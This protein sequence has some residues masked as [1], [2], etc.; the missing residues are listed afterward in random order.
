MRPNLTG[1]ARLMRKFTGCAV[2]AC[3]GAS[4]AIGCG[5][6]RTGAGSHATLATPSEAPDGV[7]SSGPGPRWAD[8]GDIA[9]VLPEDLPPGWMVKLA[10]ERAGRPRDEWQDHFE[11][12]AGRD[13]FLILGAHRL[14]S[15]SDFGFGPP[16]THAVERSDAGRFMMAL[17]FV[18]PA[19][20]SAGLTTAPSA[21]DLRAREMRWR[22]DGF[23]FIVA[24]LSASPDDALIERIGDEFGRLRS[25][26]FPIPRSAEAAG[27]TR[28]GSAAGDLDTPDYTVSW[29]PAKFAGENREAA[30]AA[31]DEGPGLW[32]NVGSRFY[33][34]TATGL[35]TDPSEASVTTRDGVLEVEFLFDGSVVRVGGRHV[36]EP[37]V[38][39]LAESLRMYER[40]TWRAD[41][42]ERLF[43]NHVEP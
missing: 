19:K 29:A 31:P 41:L 7:S 8:L 20:P 35:P 24:Q 15:A 12:F 26:D 27:F 11:F 4:I 3:F 28:V 2:A 21:K 18:L 22:S 36:G 14:S 33:A 42:G 5:T 9:Y 25:L 40:D 6:D 13:G 38:R 30:I 1:V 39:A 32:I 23:D 34:Q 43:V 37:A 17:A 16:G 10:T